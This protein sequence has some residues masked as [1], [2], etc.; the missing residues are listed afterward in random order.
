MANQTDYNKFFQGL[1]NVSGFD[2]SIESDFLKLGQVP[3]DRKSNLIDYN[4]KGFDDYR[5]ALQ[6]YLKDYFN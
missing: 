3:D 5:I 2:G 6:N 4:L 1:Y